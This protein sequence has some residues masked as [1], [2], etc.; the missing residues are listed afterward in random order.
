VQLDRHRLGAGVLDHRL[1]DREA[2]V[3]VEDLRAGLAEHHDGKEHRHLAAGHH[4]DLLGRNLDAA[5]L[6]HVGGHGLAQGHDAGSGGIAVMTV[7]QRL[8][9]G[10]HDVLRGLEVGLADAEIDDILAFAHQLRGAG[11]DGECGFRTQ[12]GHVG[13][14]LHGMRSVKARVAMAGLV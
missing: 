7:V 8:Y 6:Q 11:K 3:G 10:F 5:V 2:G 4:H 13:G 1:V 12:V 9:G 14:K